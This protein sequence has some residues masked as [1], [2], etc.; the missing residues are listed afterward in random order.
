MRLN[1]RLKT[2]EARAL[3]PP[4]LAHLANTPPR[5]WP[6]DALEAFAEDFKRRD[7]QRYA[8]LM[9]LS[10]EALDALAREA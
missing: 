1:K 2:L 7:P 3:L 4:H 6:D 10:D 5:E 8:Y 9:S